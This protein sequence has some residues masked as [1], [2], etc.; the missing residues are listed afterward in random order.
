MKQGKVDCVIIDEQPANAFVERN[1]DLSI[2]SEEFAVEEYAICIA[3]ENTELLDEVNA[4]IQTLKDNGTLEKIIQNYI[5]DSTKGQYPYE[6]P[7]VDRSN[8]ELVIATNATFEPYEYVDNGEIVGI[9]IDMSQ[10]IADELGMEL[11]VQDMEFDSI[12]SAVQTGESGYGRCR[13]DGDGR[14]LE[15][16]QLHGFV[17]H[18]DSGDHCAQRNCRKNLKLFRTYL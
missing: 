15:K 16:H 12:I 18:F 9:D 13:F 2:L 5:G 7:D 1:S 11:V 3:K 14:P 4:A 17:H 10:A 8:G 6:S